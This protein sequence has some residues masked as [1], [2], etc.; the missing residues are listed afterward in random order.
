MVF[1][2]Y[3]LLFNSSALL[4][5]FGKEIS[6]WKRERDVDNDVSFLDNRYLVLRNKSSSAPKVVS[7]VLTLGVCLCLRVS[8]EVNCDDLYGDLPVHESPNGYKYI[9]MRDRKKSW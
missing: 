5:T 3:N 2:D 4:R 6:E 7:S 8:V 1:F 9:S